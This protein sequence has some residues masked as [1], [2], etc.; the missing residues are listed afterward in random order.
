MKTTTFKT[1][2]RKFRYAHRPV[3]Q[4][5]VFIISATLGVAIA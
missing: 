2:Y 4:L 3:L 1:Q 5:L